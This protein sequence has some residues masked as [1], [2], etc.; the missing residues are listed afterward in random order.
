MQPKDKNMLVPIAIASCVA[1]YL[2]IMW[3]AFPQREIGNL[4]FAALATLLVVTWTVMT[5][6]GAQWPAQWG[7]RWPAQWGAQWPARWGAQWGGGGGGGALE[8]FEALVGD[9]GRAI[10]DDVVRP[11]LERLITATSG[12]TKSTVYDEDPDRNLREATGHDIAIA[13]GLDGKP[14]LS[15][16]TANEFRLISAFMCYCTQSMEKA[17]LLERLG[18]KPPVYTDPVPEDP[19][20]SNPADA[21]AEPAAPG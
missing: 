10:Y 16:K 6:W 5:R 9:S 21:E 19:A 8:A 15:L 18:V 14:A 12:T 1:L 11:R 2:V 3:Q 17:T 4:E 13:A 20:A 7:A